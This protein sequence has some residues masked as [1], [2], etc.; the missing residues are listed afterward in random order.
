VSVA[1]RAV[2]PTLG[3]SPHLAAC[4]RALRADRGPGIALVLVDQ[5]AGVAPEIA[6]LCDEVR[7][8]PGT[9]GFAAA[10]NLGL[11]LHEPDTEP[12]VATVND[13]VLVEPGWAA[14]L[15]AELE[16]APGLGAA[17]GVNLLLDEPALADGCGLGWNAIGQAVQVGHRRPCPAAGE[18]P[19]EIFGV[20]ATAAVYRR[21][22]LAAVSPRGAVFD[23]RLGAYLE[24]VELAVR[25]RAAGWG[26]LLVPA[27]RARHAASATG[28]TMPF[29]RARW[30]H[31]NQ[32][33]VA[34][35]LLGRGFWRRLPRLLLRSA[36]DAARAVARADAPTAAGV[37]YGT[38]AG[39]A[40]L[41]AWARGGRPLVP[42]AELGRFV[43]HSE[44]GERRGRRGWR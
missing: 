44:R 43:E 25:L 13:D 24:D 37:V 42:L 14:A 22:A 8:A 28:R 1:L 34:A 19:R 26:A 23:P 10:V 41:P 27:A 39:L 15:L 3:R 35:S 40:R 21:A 18:A 5:S 17:Q 4:L 31:A 36:A 12:F 9:R 33:L 29:R 20:S 30:L 32:L 16:R 11:G 38:A 2:V 6:G 7:P